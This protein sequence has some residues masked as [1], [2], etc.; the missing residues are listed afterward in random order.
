LPGGPNACVPSTIPSP[1]TG[2]QMLVGSWSVEQ[3]GT[4]TLFAV[5]TGE[6]YSPLSDI[7]AMSVRVVDPVPPPDLQACGR[8]HE[9]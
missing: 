8:V 7:G 2:A 3:D 5:K 1:I 4:G 9:N 6:G